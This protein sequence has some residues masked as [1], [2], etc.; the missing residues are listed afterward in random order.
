MI[1]RKL[2][3][4]TKLQ[5]NHH[6]TKCGI[7]LPIDTNSPS[8]NPEN[9]ETGES[10]L[11]N[12]S[13]QTL[14]THRESLKT[15]EQNATSSNLAGRH[16]GSVRGGESGSGAAMAGRNGKHGGRWLR[17]AAHSVGRAG[18]FTHSPVAPAIAQ[19]RSGYRTPQCWWPTCG[20]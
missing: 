18:C 2:Y 19:I 8:R 4:T 3:L 13:W 10:D 12:P 20:R 9:R 6:A 11:A 7:P 5:P 17:E 15:G 14:H 1:L 16:Y